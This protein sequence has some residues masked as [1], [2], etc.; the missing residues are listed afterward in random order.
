M[1]KRAGITPLYICDGTLA[2]SIG[3]NVRLARESL[4][5]SITQAAERL[6][7][8]ETKL[9]A[10]EAGAC[11][12][13]LLVLLKV[14]SVYDLNADE[15][16]GW[17]ATNDSRCTQKR[18]LSVQKVP[19]VVAVAALRAREAL[20]HSRKYVAM[21][22]GLTKAQIRRLEQGET[23]PDLLLLARLI[24]EFDLCADALLRRPLDIDAHQEGES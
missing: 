13:S 16:F 23:Y 8:T 5:W 1:T 10:I 14:L 20:G 2:R 11:L 18:A 17:R 22:L 3:D 6:A 7:I 15:V 12:P 19:Q 21:R 9:R 4:A 24:E